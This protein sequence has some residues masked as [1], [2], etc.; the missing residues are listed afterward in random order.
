MFD[1]TLEFV[2]CPDAQGSHRMAYWQWGQPDSGHVVLCVHGLTRQGRDFDVVAQALCQRAAD[3]GHSLR[4]VCPDVVGRG[5]SDWLKDPSGYQIPFY[6]ADM[7]ALLQQLQPVTLDWLGTSVGGL[8]GVVVAGLPEAPAFAEVR[9]LVLNDVGPVI[10]WQA[11]QRIGEYLGKTGVFETEQQAADALWTVASSF[12]PHTPAQWLALTRPM[13]KH[14]GDGSGRLT[15]HYDPALAEPF[16]A[17]TPE[18]AA[19]GEAL[20]WQSY[21]QISAKTLLVRGAESD[22][23]SPQTAQFMTQRGPRARLLE[24]AGVGHA[25]TFVADDQVQAVV[26]FLLD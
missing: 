18:S 8:I 21:D 5:K 23:L 22:L 11:L 1:P 12:G 14:L 2:N 3:T 6:A 9:R 15:L 20:L 19:Q 13:L 4:V 26:S 24:F 25:P 7:L 17:V 10:E 16:K